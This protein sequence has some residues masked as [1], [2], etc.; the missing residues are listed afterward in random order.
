MHALLVASNQQD[1]LQVRECLEQ[2]NRTNRV[3]IENFWLILDALYADIVGF[4]TL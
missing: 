1:T 2:S 4:P 3:T